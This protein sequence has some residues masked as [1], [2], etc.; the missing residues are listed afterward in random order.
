M[1][2]EWL[3]NCH[4]QEKEVDRDSDSEA[5]KEDSLEQQQRDTPRHENE[6][7]KNELNAGT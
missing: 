5:L 6:A 4:S 7:F 1:D 2:S 3:Y